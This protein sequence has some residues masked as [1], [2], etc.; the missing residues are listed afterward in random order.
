MI[1][2]SLDFYVKKEFHWTDSTTALAWIQRSEEWGTFVSNRVKE[3]RES[4][5]IVN[6]RH[7]PGVLNPA[8]LPSRGCSPRQL[9]ESQWWE[10]KDW[11]KLREDDWPSAQNEVNEEEVRI[12]LKGPKRCS[13]Q[14][15]RE[16]WS[17]VSKFSKYF[18]NVKVMGWVLRFYTN[19]KKTRHQRCKDVRLSQQEI[20]NGENQLL[21]LIQKESLVPEEKEL[22]KKL[23][24]VNKDGLLCVKT[25]L[26]NKEDSDHFRWPVI[27]PSDHPI[28]EMMVRDLHLSYGHPGVQFLLSKL[29][30]RFWILGGRRTV[31]SIVRKCIRCRR[32]DSKPAN[33]EPAALPSSRVTP[34]E[35]FQT[36]GVDL[37][38]PVILRDQTKA[39]IVLYTCAVYRCV[40]FDVVQS[41]STKAFLRSLERFI[42]M[43]GWPQG[44]IS[45]NGT[46]FVGA[47]SLM[48]IVDWKELSSKLDIQK[49]KWTFNPPSAP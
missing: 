7:V 16:Q 28:V 15:N 23:S 19:L 1:K 9:L 44:F 25:K 2:R 38:G 41:L 45:D 31:K 5:K 27:L 17:F 36:T 3:I 46:N 39:W 10:G 4:T 12:E 14:V 30:E 37:A 18:S 21:Q 8:D 20:D 29:R 43:Y 33:V 13:L 40:H 24:I 11:L 35:V 49:M 22:S 26:L 32:Y 47:D 34:G 48:N 42:N 6:W